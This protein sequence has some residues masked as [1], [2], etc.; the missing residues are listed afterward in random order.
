MPAR[1]SLRSLLTLAALAGACGGGPTEQTAGVLAHAPKLVTLEVAP[2][3]VPC[4]GV[5]PRECLQVR[6][7]GDAPWQLFYDHIEGFAFEPGYRYVLRVETHR[8]ANPPADGSSRA[9]RLLSIV[10]RMPA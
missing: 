2:A 4:V 7:A 10:S 3:R 9:Y 8:V 5:G 1:R 6:S